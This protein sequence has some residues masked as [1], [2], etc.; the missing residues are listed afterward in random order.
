MLRWSTI[1]LRGPPLR[2]AAARSEQARDVEEPQRDSRKGHV[3]F[4]F[5]PGE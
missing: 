4:S 1:A 5:S 2:G 3:A